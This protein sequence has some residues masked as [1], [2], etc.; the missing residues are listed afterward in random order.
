MSTE[1]AVE[2]LACE[3]ATGGITVLA[4]DGEAAVRVSTGA[5]AGV[6]GAASA[7]GAADGAGVLVLAVSV[8]VL[9]LSVRVPDASVLVSELDVLDA[10]AGVDEESEDAAVA[11]GAAL[12]AP[13]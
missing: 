13:L 2:V 9:A 4:P 5:G 3:A 1:P 8:R 11:A 12:C 6:D 7:A 10:L